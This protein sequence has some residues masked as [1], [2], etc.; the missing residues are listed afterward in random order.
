MQ[1]NNKYWWDGSVL[2]GPLEM[3]QP[4]E[5]I[6]GIINKYY[7]Y[8]KGLFEE[9]IASLPTLKVSEP[10]QKAWGSEGK[11]VVE[12]VDFRIAL[13]DPIGLENDKAGTKTAIPITAHIEKDRVLQEMIEDWK[14]GRYP[15][16]S[17]WSPSEKETFINGLVQ[18]AAKEIMIAF[19]AFGLK[20]HVECTVIN[21]PTDDKFSFSFRKKI[22]PA[23]RTYTLT[24]KQLSDLWDA[25]N[26]HGYAQCECDN[27]ETKNNET[28]K[29][30][31]LKDK[32]GITLNQ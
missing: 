20:T 5:R 11:I 10:L 16:F 25:A 17:H 2:R 15:D 30:Q 3:E 29:Q 32:F 22:E 19:Y 21:E 1:S 13:I 27:Y 31:Y 14:R 23:E 7:S 18:I 26:E 28:S 24:E 8:R 12:G 9:H 4:R 6:S